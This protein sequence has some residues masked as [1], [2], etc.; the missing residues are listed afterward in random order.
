MGILQT[1]PSLP[2]CSQTYLPFNCLQYTGLLTHTLHHAVP[3]GRRPR[4]AGMCPQSHFQ[5]PTHSSAGTTAPSPVPGCVHRWAC[6][7]GPL[8]SPLCT[9]MPPP[10]KDRHRAQS[11]EE[12]AKP[13]HQLFPTWT[14]HQSTGC[15]H[16]RVWDQ[17]L[18]VNEVVLPSAGGVVIP[19]PAWC[20]HPRAAQLQGYQALNRAPRWAVPHA[21]PQ[22]SA[23]AWLHPA[24]RSPAANTLIN[25]AT[26]SC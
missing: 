6:S 22:L 26:S 19:G 8:G 11:A 18:C 25:P 10:H 23:A 2:S 12:T 21:E 13:E 7:L 14:E 3:A 24:A 9:S 4:V 16:T 15:W 5:R 1:S 17:L 20:L